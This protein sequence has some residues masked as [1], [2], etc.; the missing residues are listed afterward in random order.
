[1][2]ALILA[3][4][5]ESAPIFFAISRAVSA[6]MPVALIIF[7][8]FDEGDSLRSDSLAVGAATDIDEPITII[9]ASRSFDPSTSSV[10]FRASSSSACVMPATEHSSASVAS[11]SRASILLTN[12]RAGSR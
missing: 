1:M 4:A 6:D 5:A 2:A 12:A 8:I 9:F 11:P 7:F 3:M 10:I